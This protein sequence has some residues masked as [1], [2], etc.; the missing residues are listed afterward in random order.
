MYL[1]V[2][3]LLYSQ[4]LLFIGLFGVAHLPVVTH[5]TVAYV[6]AETG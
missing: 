3:W 4:C 2:G 5:Y 1:T 6:T